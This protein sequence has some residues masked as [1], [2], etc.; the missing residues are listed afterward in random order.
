MVF[1]QAGTGDLIRQWELCN[2]EEFIFGLCIS[3]GLSSSQVRVF[4]YIR[5]QSH[6]ASK[7]SLASFTSL[8]EASL[9]SRTKTSHWDSKSVSLLPLPT[10]QFATTTSSQLV[11][12]TSKPVVAKTDAAIRTKSLAPNN[13]VDSS[14]DDFGGGAVEQSTTIVSCLHMS[15]VDG[16]LDFVEPDQSVS[17]QDPLVTEVRKS[18]GMPLAAQ[19]NRQTVA[20]LRATRPRSN[21]MGPMRSVFTSVSPIPNFVITLYICI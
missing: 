19:L 15:D 6:N 17:N 3:S 12:A 1:W 7:L 2:S 16:L 20:H 21:R 5:I 11:N 13:P 9:S 4:P 18:S 14:I 8:T 10:N